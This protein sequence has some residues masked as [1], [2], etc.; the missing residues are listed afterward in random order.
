LQIQIWS[1]G[2]DVSDMVLG[3]SQAQ[4]SP[5]IRTDLDGL[6]SDWPLLLV[7]AEPVAWMEPAAGGSALLTA[8]SELLAAGQRCRLVNLSCVSLPALVAW[9][10][11]PA[12]PPPPESSPRFS[13]PE[14]FEALLAIELLHAYPEQLQAY[15]A[16]EAHPLAA[17]LDQRPPDLGCLERYR[18]AASLEALLQARQEWAALEADL[19]ELATQL[20]PLHHQQLEALAL[21]EQLG[22]LQ[23]RLQEADA[24]QARCSDLQ[25]SF[26]AQQQDLEQLARRLA[27]LEQLVGA[28]SDASLRLQTR[29]AQALA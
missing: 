25:L 16:L 13:Q 6:T 7:Y 11:E 28:G 22:A 9:C 8:L 29:L 3:M 4:L 23:A 18:Q 1:P 14:P 27:L 24:L 12:S 20:E 21:R 26:Q 2:L 19:R 17:A 10:V 15:Q 5:L